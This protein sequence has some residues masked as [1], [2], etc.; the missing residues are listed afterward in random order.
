MS[1]V[2]EIPDDEI[3]MQD[4]VKLTVTLN[5][6]D[7]EINYLPGSTLLDSVLATDLKGVPYSCR[8]GHC[9]TCMSILKKGEVK[10]LSNRILSKRD[11]AAG[12]VLAC[13]SIPLSND[14][15]IDFDE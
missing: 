1:K 15:W 14:V 8:E 12:Y 7:V 6:I 10:M 13:Q 4:N 9:G 2:S 3:A 5:D 11:L